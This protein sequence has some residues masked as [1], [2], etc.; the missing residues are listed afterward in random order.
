M[1]ERVSS[2]D[3]EIVVDLDEVM[4]E[5]VDTDCVCGTVSVDGLQVVPSLLGPKLCGQRVQVVAPN[6]VEKPHRSILQD[7]HLLQPVVILGQK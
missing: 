1:L 3:F 4:E 6:S 5:D 2:C 7:I